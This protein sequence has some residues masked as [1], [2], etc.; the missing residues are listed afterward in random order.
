MPIPVS[1][2]WNLFEKYVLL[3]WVYLFLFSEH[4]PAILKDYKMEF[5]LSG[6]HH[7]EPAYSGLAESPGSEVHGVAFKM[8]LESAENL[9]RNESPSYTKEM[10]TLQS[11]NGR[12]LAGFIFMNKKP[13]SLK[14]RPSARY[15]GV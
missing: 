5:N 3:I 10:V 13:S 1:Y 9:T 14:L 4:T 11:Y 2:K 15:L 7:A 6:L 12:D 8:S